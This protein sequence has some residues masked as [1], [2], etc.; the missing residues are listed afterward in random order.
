MC[1]HFYLI[2]FLILLNG[3]VCQD[4]YQTGQVVNQKMEE[5]GV[6]GEPTVQCGIDSLSLEI[7]TNNP[8][9]GRLFIS[10][11]SQEKHCQLLGN[12]SLQRLQFTVQ[13]GQ[14]GLRRSRELNGISV[15]TI[16][17]VSFHPI[18]VTKLDRAYRLNCFYT[19]TRKTFTQHL[20][21]G[22]LTTSGKP[23]SK[24]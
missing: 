15:Q 2:L 23:I 10:G 4:T 9:S 24:E 17:I 13:F 14:C 22:Q 5:N 21:V 7:K 18:F 3:L 11:F 6:V 8:F 19:E 20:E 1:L 12:G 16:V